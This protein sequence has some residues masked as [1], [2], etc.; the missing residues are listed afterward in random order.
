MSEVFPLV[1]RWLAVVGG[2]ALGWFAIGLLVHGLCQLLGVRSVPKPPFVVARCLGAVAAGWAIWLLVF[3]VGGPHFGGPGGTRTGSTSDHGHDTAEKETPPPSVK[4]QPE[5]LQIKILG[6]SNKE[7][8]RL[9]MIVGETEELTRETLEVEL[10]KRKA[11]G[12]REFTF[13]TDP[14]SADP[15]NNGDVIK[16]TSWGKEHGLYQGR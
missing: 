8:R 1:A 10:L 5:I 16:L 14:N 11:L 15:I 4:S 6:G 2:A 3:G 7:D 12:L 13:T 9:F